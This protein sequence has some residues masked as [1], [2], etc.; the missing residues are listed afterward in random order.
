MHPTYIST[1]LGVHITST[2]PY[3]M[4]STKDH[5]QIKCHPIWRK[6]RLLNPSRL[7]GHL[8]LKGALSLTLNKFIRLIL[9][10]AWYVHEA[11]FL[12]TKSLLFATLRN[13][14]FLQLVLHFYEHLACAQYT[15]SFA[16]IMLT[17]LPTLNKLDATCN[18]LL[19]S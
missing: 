9:S 6:S 10:H 13:M 7:V 3:W 11:I 5:L 8:Q 17:T 19:S 2:T 14:L 16:Q 12:L 18:V 4:I 15:Y 1:V